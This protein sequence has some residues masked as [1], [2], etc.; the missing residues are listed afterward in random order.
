MIG[1]RVETNGFRRMWKKKKVRKGNLEDE[2]TG[3]EGGKR[4]MM[5]NTLFKGEQ[6]REPF[7]ELSINS[8][9]AFERLGRWWKFRFFQL[10]SPA[11]R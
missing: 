8:L 10:A 4:G 3:F 11:P 7:Q 2:K 9:L 1:C 6:K 5:K